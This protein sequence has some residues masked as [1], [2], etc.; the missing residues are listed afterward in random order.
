MVTPKAPAA[1]STFAA[2]NHTTGSPDDGEG[3]TFH[4]NPPHIEEMAPMVTDGGND[5]P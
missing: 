1:M 5:R 2:A 3:V 4:C